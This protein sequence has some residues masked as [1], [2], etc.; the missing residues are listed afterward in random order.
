MS[1]RP[2]IIRLLVATTSSLALAA[3]SDSTAPSGA[4]RVSL[5][6]ASA[7][8][9]G[10]TA[11]SSSS[12]ASVIVV[13][14]DTLRLSRVR[15]VL[16][17]IELYQS[18]V[19]A[20]GGGSV[21]ISAQLDV[22]VSRSSSSSSS[23]DDDCGE[24]ETGPFLVDLGVDGSL[25]APIDVSIPAGSYSKLELK[26]RPVSASSSSDAGFRAAHPELA[27]AS[28]IVDGTFRGQA[29]T[30]RTS[31]EAEHELYFQPPLVVSGGTRVTVSIDV[32]RWFRTSAGAII[33]PSTAAPGGP[34]AGIVAANIAASFEAY[35]DRDRDGRH[36]D[37][38][39]NHS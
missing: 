37:D 30:Y 13:G 16:D 34:F 29:F 7:T 35:E 12:N 19:A 6:F 33:D 38:G 22:A 36:D 24:L 23:S 2:S 18:G 27:G 3:C 21:Q 25:T 5:S 20:C 14:T 17:E 39:P 28:V 26:L 9:A 8:S 31:L 15:L 11:G 10:T 4:S 1:R 32:G